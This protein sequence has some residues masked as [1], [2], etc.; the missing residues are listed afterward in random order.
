MALKQWGLGLK[1]SVKN[2]SIPNVKVLFLKVSVI[3][4]YSIESTMPSAGKFLN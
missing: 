4:I 1:D 3:N 2:E